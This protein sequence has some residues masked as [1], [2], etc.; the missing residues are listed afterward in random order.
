M[1]TSPPGPE[2]RKLDQRVD[3]LETLF[4]HLERT[5]KDLDEV[6]LD[7]HRRMDELGRQLDQLEEQVQ[8]D[9]QPASDGSGNAQTDDP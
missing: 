5:V 4:T 7:G 6:V 3:E 8:P 2:R 9:K 1:T